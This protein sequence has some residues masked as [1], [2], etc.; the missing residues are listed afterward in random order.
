M[1]KWTLFN[2]CIGSFKSIDESSVKC[3][4]LWNSIC[5]ILFAFV[6]AFTVVHK[7]LTKCQASIPIRHQRGYHYFQFLTLLPVVKKWKLNKLKIKT[8]HLRII[9][10]ETEIHNNFNMVKWM[11][12]EKKNLK[13][14]KT[15][16]INFKK[17]IYYRY[18]KVSIWFLFRKKMVFRISF[19]PNESPWNWGT[20]ITFY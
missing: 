20:F 3:F 4:H 8:K 14:K 2:S 16:I 7:Y 1:Q 15:F 17:D 11:K 12:I 9:K 19:Y 13:C 6:F 10:T 18:F 5:S